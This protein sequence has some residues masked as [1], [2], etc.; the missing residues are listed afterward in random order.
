MDRNSPLSFLAPALAAGFALFGQQAQAQVFEGRQTAMGGTGVA[1]ARYLSAPLF[2]PALLTRYKEADTWGL[3]LP[4]IGAFA[5]D[6]DKLVD[7]VDR[8]QSTF[9]ELERRL[10]MGQPSLGLAV[11]AVQQLQD[12]DN[13]TATAAIGVNFVIAI[14]SDTL[15]F[16]IVGRTY[17]DTRITPSVDPADYA[18][19]S[20]ATTS[21]QLNNVQSEVRVLGAAI[22][23]L[24]LSFAKS[25]SLGI[26]E[27]SL[28]VTPKYQRVDTFNYALTVNN[29]DEEDFDDE[30][31]RNDDSGFNLDVGASLQVGDHLTFG[32]AVRDAIS[33]EYDTV[34]TTGQAFQYMVSPKVTVGAAWQGET[35]TFS[36]DADVTEFERF[37]LNDSSRFVRAGVEIDI[38]DWVQIRAGGSF[39]TE[40]TVA[41]NVTAGIGLSPF[42]VFHI[43]VAG[44]IGNDDTYG[45][46][47]QTSF[48]F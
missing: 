15:G 24:G 2:N 8:F 19:I 31:F 13:K 26:G 22:S 35:F 39:D 30:R 7:R 18:L 3:L 1:A 23:D 6:N 20:T 34:S 21:A 38:A 28:G 47:V 40:D 46:A 4:T 32:A 9:D 17:L 43:D 11:D 16:A 37:D 25:F 29:F 14:P 12:I 36:V 48:T 45:A 44:L 27:L 41:D 5:E 33:Q 10:D 42:D